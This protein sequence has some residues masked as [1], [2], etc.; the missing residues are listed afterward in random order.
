[1]AEQDSFDRAE[2]VS[3]LKGNWARQTIPDTLWPPEDGNWEGVKTEMKNEI[4]GNDI[5]Q[6]IGQNIL[7][8][9]TK[10]ND[11]SSLWNK[12]QVS[13]LVSEFGPMLYMLSTVKYYVTVFPYCSADS[14]KHCKDHNGI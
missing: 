1:M 2:V 10:E 5:S 8:K 14:V 6:E 13:K 9:L 7:T 4:N 11:K 12:G 3:F